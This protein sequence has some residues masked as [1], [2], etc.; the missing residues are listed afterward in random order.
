MYRSAFK[1]PSIRTRDV[2]FVYPISDIECKQETIEFLGTS[3][4]VYS[5]QKTARRTGTTYSVNKI[6]CVEPEHC[7]TL[8][9]SFV[10][11]CTRIVL[12]LYAG[13][14]KEAEQDNARPHVARIVRTF[15]DTEKVRLLFWLA[16]ST[17]VLPIENVWSMG[18]VRLTRHHT[19]VTT[20][21]E[22]WHHVEAAWA[23]VPIHTI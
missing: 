17:D 4:H 7:V 23:S 22:L 6:L 19:I 3:R 20:V 21:A 18:A 8:V 11:K 15:L 14:S 10:V 12:P 5:H 1:L 2:C 13:L 9:S 16:R